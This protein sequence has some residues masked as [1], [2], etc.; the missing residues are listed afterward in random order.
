M[1]TR[2]D[3][4]QKAICVNCKYCLQETIE[5]K[6]WTEYKYFCT[7]SVSSLD[8]VK[9]DETYMPCIMI[10]TDAECENFEVPQLTKFE[11]FIEIL[12]GKKK[13]TNAKN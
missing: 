2:K 7:N 12:T 8:P 4:E 3:I 11:R 13:E 1:L 6:H 5:H 9:G 10:N